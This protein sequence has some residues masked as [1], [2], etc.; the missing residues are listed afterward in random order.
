MMKCPL[1][2]VSGRKTRVRG[3]DGRRYYLC[4][5]CSLIF[6]DPGD[7]LSP[8]EEKGHYETHENSIENAGYV[9][10]LKRLVDP[11]LEY[12]ERGMRGLD[13]G[14]G[15]GPTLSLLLR[16]QGI[17]CEDYDPFFADGPLHP[18]YD[19]VLSTECFEHFHRPAEE[20]ER[21]RSLLK[22][23]GLLGI[24]TERWRT[25]DGFARWYYTRD[26][27]HVSFYHV[28]SLNFI[29]RRFGCTNLWMDESRVAILRRNTSPRFVNP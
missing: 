17:D 10:F 2:S 12:L 9:R 5:C 26:P 18:P 4:G 7:F 16:R 11:M 1:C 22:P 8:E 24:M 21:M 13:Y 23:G 19:L 20:V 3:A 25:L 14:C 6:V 15:H 28:E 27:T 29:C